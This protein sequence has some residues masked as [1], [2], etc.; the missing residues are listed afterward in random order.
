MGPF[1]L[2][3]G[4]G[5]EDN[6]AAVA[7]QIKAVNPFSKV[8]MYQNSQFAY[9][10]Y[11]LYETA[12][13][14]GTWWVKNTTTGKEVTH[15]IFNENCTNSKPC[16]GVTVG[17]WDFTQEGLRAAWVDTCTKTPSIDGCFIDGAESDLPPFSKTD[18]TSLFDAGRAATFKAIAAAGSLV[19]I[20]D[21]K[22][23]DPAPPYPSAQGEFIETF[24]G[25]DKKWLDILNR[26]TDGHLVEA[27]TGARAGQGICHSDENSLEGIADL[28]AF[29]LAAQEYSYFGC[30]SWEDV[31]TWPAVY[32]KPLGAPLGQATQDSD[33]TW[34][35]NFAR[36]T[37]VSLNYNKKTA[38]IEWG[39]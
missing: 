29:L 26:T 10:W 15:T 36:G 31:P 22:Y 9:P 5:E 12:M 21:K 35:R 27:H 1:P 13:L 34:H 25:S 14:N 4:Q 17:Y 37:K 32:D 23:Y 8:L 24:S 38:N 30:S 33:G 39:K 6:I 18:N 20:N 28:A 7:A 3:A 2:K 19:V 16:P 11:H